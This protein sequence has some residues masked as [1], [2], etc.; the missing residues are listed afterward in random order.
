M[1]AFPHLPISPSPHLHRT[2]YP[3][4][5]ASRLKANILRMQ[6]LATHAGVRLRPHAKTHK[7]PVIARMQLEAGA[8]G[9]C[10][11]KLGEAEVFA[12]PFAAAIRDGE[13]A[14]VMNSYASV[15]G[16]A[17]AGSA[18]LLTELRALRRLMIRHPST[19]IQRSLSLFISLGHNDAQLKRLSEAQRE[20]GAIILEALAR[21]APDCKVTTLSGGGSCWVQVPDNVPTAQLVQRAAERGVLVEAGD[22]FFQ[23]TPPRGHFI[24]LGF[25]S[26]KAGVIEAGIAELGRVIKDLQAG[27]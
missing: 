8:V 23:S 16:L 11:A 19:F 6:A 14:S 25:Q 27:R 13:L 18:A 26:I 12:E 1:S 7:S 5:S 17:P 4:V 20:R 3:V 10:C 9:I 2:P 24:R 22:V 15:D 21:H